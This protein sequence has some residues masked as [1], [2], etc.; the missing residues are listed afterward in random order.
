METENNKTWDEAKV[1]RNNGF[2]KVLGY[3]I[4]LQNS[5]PS[6]YTENNYLKNKLRKI[7]L[8]QHKKSKLLETNLTLRVKNIYISNR[9]V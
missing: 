3:K 2:S 6:L 1:V 7:H 9:K 5:V 4:N 8:Q